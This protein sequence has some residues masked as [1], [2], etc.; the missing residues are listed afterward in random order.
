MKSSCIGLLV[1]LL[2]CAL[3]VSSAAQADSAAA[4]PIPHGTRVRV[5]APG[6]FRGAVTGRVSHTAA[7]TLFLTRRRRGLVAVPVSAIT[8]TEISRGVNRWEGLLRGA[9][10]GALAGGVV[11][12]VLIFGGDTDCEYCLPGRDPGAAAVGAL[13][14]AVMFTPVGAVVGLI[15]GREHW[16]PAEPRFGVSYLP[17]A[18]GLGIR[19]TVRVP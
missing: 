6:A 8:R 14:G 18:P 12:G 10:I 4:E 2:C 3:P 9:G 15:K 1:F 17:H 13:I 16:G 7:D 5:T 11:G 19:V